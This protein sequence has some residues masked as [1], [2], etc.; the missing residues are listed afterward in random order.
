VDVLGLASGGDDRRRRVELTGGQGD[1]HG[2]VVAVAGHDDRRGALHLGL[3]EHRGTAR[4]AVDRGEPAAGG[5]LDRVA[6]D[7]DDEDLVRLRARGEQRGDRSA[8]LGSE[9][10]DDPTRM[11]RNTIRAGVMSRVVASREPSVIGA[12]SP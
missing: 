5:L 3:L 9:A 12:M 2:A 4:G 7:V 11:M 10:A 8:A 1:E 6:V